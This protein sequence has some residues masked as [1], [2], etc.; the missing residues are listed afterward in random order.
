MFKPYFKTKDETSNKMN[1]GS[2][3]IGLSFCKRV[4]KKLGGDLIL[5]EAIRDGCEFELSLK[6]KKLDAPAKVTTIYLM[7]FSIKK[8]RA[9]ALVGSSAK[10]SS[11]SP[12]SKLLSLT[13][14]L[15]FLSKRS[16]FHRLRKSNSRK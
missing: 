4:A 14:F 15:R 7:S 16:L 13:Q 5:N 12:P 3:G 9:V 8:S 6:L 2:H 11:K 10:S 1:V